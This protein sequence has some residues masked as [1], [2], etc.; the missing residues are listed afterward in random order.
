MEATRVFGNLTRSKDTRDFLLESGAWNQLLIF[1]D[2]DD[3]ELLCT[4]IGILVNMMA[5]WDK[6]VALK[7]GHGI[8]RYFMEILVPFKWNKLSSRIM[9]RAQYICLC[10][11]NVRCI[12]MEKNVSI[13][14]VLCFGYYILQCFSLQVSE[15]LL[16]HEFVKSCMIVSYLFVLKMIKP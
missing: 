10:T 8:E 4:T 12:S 9:S 3:Q 6:R 11:E 13:H 7:E 5:D 14:N 16:V 1:L 15:S 2:W